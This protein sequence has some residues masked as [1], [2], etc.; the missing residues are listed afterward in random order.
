MHCSIL[1]HVLLLF[2][3]PFHDSGV[4]C[5]GGGAG[6]VGWGGGGGGGFRMIVCAC[7]RVNPCMSTQTASKKLRSD[8]ADYPFTLA[9][10]M[11]IK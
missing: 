4:I 3:I 2:T 11:M 10:W 9:L 8:I 6:V 7:V 1:A 5:V